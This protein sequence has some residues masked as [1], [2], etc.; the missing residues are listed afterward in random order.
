MWG[1]RWPQRPWR[2]NDSV[3]VK[4]EMDIM[5]RVKHENIVAFRGLC[6]SMDPAAAALVTAFATG[7]ELGDALYKKHSIRNVC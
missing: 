4:D 5:A 6:L 2:R 3:S 1:Q 7:G